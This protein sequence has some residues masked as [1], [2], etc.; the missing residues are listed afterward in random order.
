MFFAFVRLAQILHLAT[1]DG[2]DH[3]VLDG[4]GPF[5]AAVILDLLCRVARALD[6]A[7]DSVNSELGLATFTQ[8]RGEAGRVP[9]G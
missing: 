6:A 7:F 3:V 5:L 2:D 4:V 1:L 8:L 9:F